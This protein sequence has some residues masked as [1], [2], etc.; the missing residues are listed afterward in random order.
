MF[1]N[2]SKGDIKEITLKTPRYWLLMYE[3]ETAFHQP[4]MKWTEFSKRSIRHQDFSEGNPKIKYV[5]DVIEGKV[6]HST[7][8]F[9]ELEMMNKRA[10]PLKEKM[11]Q[12]VSERDKA[13]KLKRAMGL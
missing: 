2:P 7:M 10:W 8:T 11:L 3:E 5:L 12:A 4:W 6:I 13:K 1:T 9:R